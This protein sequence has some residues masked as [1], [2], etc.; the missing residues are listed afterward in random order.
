M[1]ELPIDQ[2]VQT[3]GDYRTGTRQRALPMVTK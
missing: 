2:I 1:K 3:P